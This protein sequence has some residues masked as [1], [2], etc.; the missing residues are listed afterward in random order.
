MNRR[1]NLTK[2]FFVLLVSC[3]S[4][5]AGER[6]VSLG[7][8]ETNYVS[9]GLSCLVSDSRSASPLPPGKDLV[10]TLRNDGAK[11]IRFGNITTTNFSLRDANGQKMDV[12]LRSSTEDVVITYGMPTVI[13]LEVT[14]RG[15]PQPWTLH[16]HSQSGPYHDPFDLTITGIKPPSSPRK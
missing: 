16:F 14:T 11:L 15:A 2:I 13:Q 1:L 10:L 3:S 5:F 8:G 4:L 6:F 7:S 12:Y 9:Y